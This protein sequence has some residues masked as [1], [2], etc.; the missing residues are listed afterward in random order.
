MAAPSA[1]ASNAPTT[2]GET[3]IER[4]AT[5]IAGPRPSRVGWFSSGMPGVSAADAVS[6]GGLGVLSQLTGNDDF[7]T[8]VGMVNLSDKSCQVRVR[9]KNAVGTNVGSAE[10]RTL[11]AYSFDQINDVFAETGAGSRNNAYATVEVL[12][13][14]CEVWA[15][16][17]GNFAFALLGQVRF[18]DCL[19]RFP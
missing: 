5:L 13:S 11:A 19:D 4:S 2:F 6:T 18:G 8:N 16:G 1:A 9:V 15:Y 3:M 17:A 14:G 7:R 12:T 10:I